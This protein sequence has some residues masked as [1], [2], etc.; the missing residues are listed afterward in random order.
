MAVRLQRA[1][2]ALAASLAIGAAGAVET[3]PP[4]VAAAKAGR[5][6]AALELIEQGLGLDDAEADGTTALH[7][8][9]QLADAKL[10]AALLAAGA[11][12]NAANRY[13]MT[14]AH[15]AAVN[16][17]AVTLRALLEAGADANAVLP[18]GETVLL[19]AARTGSA[20]AIDVLV[21]HGA[22]LDAREKWHGETA[23]I[24]AAAENHADAVRT[25]LKHGADPNLRSAPEVWEKRRASQSLLPLGEWSPLFYAARANALDAGRALVEAGANL[26]AADPDGATAL[27]IAILNAHYEFA[28][29]LIE[30]G[31][32]TNIVDTSGMGAL[33]A[34][35][36]MHRLT[37][38]H[39][40]PNPRP[41]G[42]LTAPD[43]VKLLLEHGADPNAA[44]SNP[45]IQRQHTFGDFSQGAGTTPLLRAA[46]S[47]DIELVKLLVA[48]GAN[49]QHTLPSG[50]N[51]MMFAAGLGWR[52]G[53]PAAPSFD[54]G[55]DAEAIETLK[56]LQQ[57]GLDL[58]AQD[59][60]GNT[61]LHAAIGGR[62]SEPIIAYLL[63]DAKADTTVRNAKGQTPY[64][65]AQAKRG[66]AE[67]A[68]A[69]LQKLGL[70][71]SGSAP[72]AA[73]TAPAA[74][75]APARAA[76]VSPSGN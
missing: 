28:A 75:A 12:P 17:D 15:L 47:G 5:Q 11:N 67:A 49:V 59:K 34:A 51:A 16:G 52:N 40:R 35:V 63:N 61:A 24:W 4:L 31:A 36:D 44:L 27:V 1:A 46:K 64:E 9:A 54:Q 33:Y 50:A 69:M 58:N 29:L 60:D 48:G 23:L 72:A 10:A 73:P 22:K 18:E 8:A 57:L 65:F 13:G 56:Y 76:G 32:D 71:P 41:V 20:P 43:V 14:P 2:L 6:A 62:A 70:G 55:T 7:W 26:N 74:G 39:G 53:S 3:L 30:A 45:T 66:G 19:S 68:V 21:E 37:I 25:L 38:G 42:L